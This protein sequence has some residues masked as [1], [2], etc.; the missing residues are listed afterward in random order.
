M[1]IEVEASHDGKFWCGRGIRADFFTQGK[2]LDGHM[3]N[4]KEAAA[5]HLEDSL[6]I[7]DVVELY[8]TRKADARLGDSHSV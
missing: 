7:R 6:P 4:V 5:L 8:V 1:V 3:K 2:T